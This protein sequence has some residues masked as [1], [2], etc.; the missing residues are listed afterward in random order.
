[1]EA[2][3]RLDYLLHNQI[4]LVE[5]EYLDGQESDTEVEVAAVAGTTTGK[6]AERSYSLVVHVA[7]GRV[8]DTV[9]ATVAAASD[10]EAFQLT[11]LV[12]S[13]DMGYVVEAE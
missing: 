13:E 11:E 7:L 9:L 6:I 5:E 3:S 10:A 1:M 12:N 2:A 8:P 4:E